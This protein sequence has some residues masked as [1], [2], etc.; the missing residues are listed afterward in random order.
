M[1][2]RRRFGSGWIGTGC[3]DFTRFDRSASSAA[4]ATAGEAVVSLIDKPPRDSRIARRPPNRQEWHVLRHLR[5][6]LLALA[7]GVIATPAAIADPG[8]NNPN[9]TTRVFMNCTNGADQLEVVFVGL[10]GV[11]FNVTTDQSVFVFKTITIDRLPLG[12]SP[13]DE[14]DDR[15]IQGFAGQSLTTCEYVTPSC[16]QV[17]VTGFFTPRT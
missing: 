3:R 15:G 17:T 12:P 5:L 1:S 6:V 11:N 8:E 9:A 7:V 10:E 14:V 4:A 13:N 2:R 16:S